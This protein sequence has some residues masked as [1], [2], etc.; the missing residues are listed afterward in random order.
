MTCRILFERH[1]QDKWQYSALS[2]EGETAC[3]GS[4]APD[5]HT[6]CDGVHICSIQFQPKSAGVKMPVVHTE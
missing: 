5:N 2:W 1:T 3:E 6:Q 4:T